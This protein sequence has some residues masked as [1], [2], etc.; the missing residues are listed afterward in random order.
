M[1]T[2]GK[3]AFWS[4]MDWAL[5][6]RPELYQEYKRTL[7]PLLRIDILQKLLDEKL[8]V[9]STWFF[10]LGFSVL[11]ELG[12]D[13]DEAYLPDANERPLIKAIGG[14]CAGKIIVGLRPG[15]SENIGFLLV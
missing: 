10:M 8:T 9:D 15:Q 12:F 5:L 1:V 13:V 3:E 6:I 2:L 14:K 11:K 7:S 4:L